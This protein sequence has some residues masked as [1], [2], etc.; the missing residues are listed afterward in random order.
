MNLNKTL[1]SIFA[2]VILTNFSGYSQFVEPEIKIII[3]E[4]K[5]P[6]Y[7][8]DI[9]KVINRPIKTSFLKGK[10]K[11][12]DRDGNV[13][14]L[15]EKEKN[16]TITTT[17]KY[18]DNLLIERKK[19]VISDKEKIEKENKA[20][21]MIANNN[22]YEEYAIMDSG[23]SEFLYSAVLD[24]KGRIVTFTNQSLNNQRLSSNTSH[25][26]YNK[27]KINEI[28]SKE[29]IDKF[30]YNNDLLTS[31]YS[32]YKDNSKNYDLKREYVFDS[33]NNLIYI[34]KLHISKEKVNTYITDSIHYDD[35]NRI[36]LVGNSFGIN[37][38]EYNEN[39]QIIKSYKYTKN[40]QDDVREYTYENDLLRTITFYSVNKK[41]EKKFKNEFF[42]KYEN[43]KLVSY[44]FRIDG[45]TLKKGVYIYEGDLLLN[46][47]EFVLE[48][49][50]DDHQEDSFKISNEVNYS[51]KDD[52]LII[53][54]KK[55][56][57]IKSVFY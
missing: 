21:E 1:R 57:Y 40:Y 23:N 53:S 24:R 19:I 13:L 12:Y 35:K 10:I 8:Y 29:K 7:V 42:Y 54:D 36:I 48:T 39:D 25:I 22:G 16:Q 47:K 6:L 33:Y 55:G 37:K 30:T 49:K 45:N 28:D 5:D 41:L 31:Q 38:F 46:S 3:P 20:E 11:E 50:K 27:N 44:E 17:F 4:V 34:K 14:K 52:V 43:N 56:M 26:K 32:I 18:K 15:T 9:F 51:Y 2:F